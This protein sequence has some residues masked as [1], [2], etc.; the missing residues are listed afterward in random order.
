M[1][2]WFARNGVAANL[3]MGII[4]VGGIFSI[5][6]LKMELFPDFDLDI[7]SIHVPYPGA[8]PL[9][10]EEGIC[11]QIEEKIWDLAGIKELTSFARENGGAVYVH[12]ERGKDPKV[13]ADEIKVRVDSILTFPENAERPMVEVA[14]QKRQVLALAIHGNTDEKSLRKLADKTLNELTNLPG[15]TQVDIAGIRRPEIGIDVSERSLREYQL[16]FDQIALALRKSSV[17][18]PGGVARTSSGETLLRSTGKARDGEE[19][20]QIELLSSPNGSSLKLGDIA[21][22]RDAFEDKT[23]YTRFKGLP[24]VTLRVFRVGKQSPLD[25]S[26]KVAAYVNETKAT[27]PEGISMTIWKDS[28][29]YLR[30]RLEMMIN[31]ALQGLILVFLVLSFFLRPSLA[32]WVALGL[33]ISFMGAFATMG[34]VGASINL[35]S[36]FAFIV[37]LGI[38]VD[39]AIVVGESVYTLGSKGKKP[40]DAS[41]QG[42]HLVAMPV[43]FAILTSMVA[44][45]PMLFLP[46]WLGKLMMDI[47]LVV[48]PA[49]FFSLIESKFILPYHLS[50]CRFDRKPKSFLLKLQNRVATG[51]ESFIV[52]YYQPVLKLCLRNRYLTIS[53]FLGFFAITIG[54]IV[55]G[56][57]P[58]IRGVPP[59]PSDYIS[60][61]LTMQEGV[62][63][64]TTENAVDMVEK[65]RREVI[66]HLSKKNEGNP[67][68]HSMLTMGAQPFSGGPRGSAHIPSGSN[69]GEVSVELIKSEDRNYTAPQIS[70]MWRDRIGPLPGLK[71]IRFEDIAAGGEPTAIDIEISGQDFSLMTEAAQVLKGR[72]RTYEGLYDIA[73]NYSGGKKELKLSLKKAGLALGLTQAD[74]GRQVRQA[75]YGEEV[76]RLQRDRDEVKVMLRY[77]LNDRK[78]LTA[79]SSLR[80][81]APGGVEAPLEEVCKIE[82]G[83]GYPSIERSGRSRIINILASA[84]KE[85]S[86]IPAI[87]DDLETNFIP[88]LQERFPKLRFSFVGEK[89]EQ[90]ESDS[91]LAQAGAICLF[92]I[93]GLLAIPFR[94]Y[95]QPFIIMSVIPFGLIGAV[96]GHFLFG[97]PLSQLSHF[98]LVALTGVVINDS[99]VMV[100]Y[101]NKR[102]KDTTLIDAARIAGMARFRPILLTSLTTFVGLLPIL[103]ERSLQAQ[104]LK[105]MAIAIG[106]GVLFATFITLLMLP[107]LY[108]ILHDLQRG[109]RKALAL[110][111]LRGKANSNDGLAEA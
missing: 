32:G 96:L 64:S 66:V 53:G 43:T 104:F 87:E 62:P 107:C 48:I 22:V 78:S 52:H 76:Q 5:R 77:P 103:F 3:L 80:I 39:D 46:G 11:K 7:V 109:L 16:S 40:I 8:A 89:K 36:L 21:T 88:R 91:S 83:Q 95:V 71:E 14:T 74:L 75:Y 93:Y 47:P 73:D 25:I 20:E 70:K 29:F 102:A 97:L 27:L 110:L 19:F 2:A 15:I 58:S 68:R 85:V 79:L 12:V 51:L 28:S 18:L 59:V 98:G 56:H 60:V 54:L 99:L 55:G 17:D 35:V 86:D 69:M 111:G 50:L 10:V 6:G 72:L 61:K 4:L 1:I 13:L 94:S 45:V 33:P 82:L 106:F 38:L 63:A 101:V 31:N 42:T 9:E 26:E 105:P 49:L 37:V 44:F 30:G 92:V 90:D 34:L 67:F 81:R 41:I 57:V 23:L 24:A 65:A 84:N 108:L 100:H